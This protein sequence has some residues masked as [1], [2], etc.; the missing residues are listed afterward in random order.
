MLPFLQ[1]PTKFRLFDGLLL[2]LTVEKYQKKIIADSNANDLL[3]AK[4]N[5]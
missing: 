2:I 5:P 1:I 3:R 4:N